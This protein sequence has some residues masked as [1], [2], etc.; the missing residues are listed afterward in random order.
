MTSRPLAGT[1][2]RGATR[3]G[4]Q[5]RWRRSCWPTRRSGPSTSCWS[6]CTATTSA[7]WRRSA[8][9]K[10]TDVMTVERYSHVMHITQQRDRARS[11]RARRRST[12]C[13]V[14]LPVGHGQRRAE[15]PGDADHRRAGADPPRPLRRRGRLHRFRRQHG[16]LHRPADDR[17]AGSGVYDVQAGAGVVADSV[18]APE[19]EE[20]MNKAKAML[21]AVEIAEKGF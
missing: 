11:R 10:V 7:G 20:T 17:L 5:A 16:H 21:K 12:R 2:R 9:V 18:P 19:Y 4:G 13:G 1:R 15:G 6:T 3:G 8:R 14:S